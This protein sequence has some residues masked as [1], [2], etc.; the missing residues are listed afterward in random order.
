MY[1]YSSVTRFNVPH[2]DRQQWV[3]TFFCIRLSLSG[4][5]TYT[6]RP[7]GVNYRVYLH[8]VKYLLLIILYFS[9]KE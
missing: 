4:I 8:V 1:W 6:H 9:R 7:Q 3:I 5:A 2:A